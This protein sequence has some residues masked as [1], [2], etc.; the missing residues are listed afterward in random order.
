L[1]GQTNEPNEEN[2][3]IALPNTGN[4]PGPTLVVTEPRIENNKIYKVEKYT[5]LVDTG[6]SSQSDASISHDTLQRVYDHVEQ[7][8][9]D[10]AYTELTEKWK[11]Q[12][13]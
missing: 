5:S 10:R 9:M 1:Y 6:V 8:E 7:P 13:T 4:Q 11:S 12:M 2:N 3:F